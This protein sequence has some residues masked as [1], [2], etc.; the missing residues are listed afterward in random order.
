MEDVIAFP[1]P[2]AAGDVGKDAAPP[3]LA[4]S[5]SAGWAAKRWPAENFADLMLRV[6]REMGWPAV[7]NCG[8]GEEELAQG[9]VA[10]AQPGRA[11]IVS[12][13]LGALI[14]VA[15]RASAF[16]AGD[17]DRYISPPRWEPRWWRCLVPPVRGG[18]VRIPALARGFAPRVWKLLTRARPAGKISPA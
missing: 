4:V 8:P 7:V 10:K 2:G 13:D 18:T 9:I 1:L 12:G 15:R 16:V 17:T 14:G 3:F 11:R 5:P 6:D